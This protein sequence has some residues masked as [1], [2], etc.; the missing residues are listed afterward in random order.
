[1]LSFFMSL[2]YNLRVGLLQEKSFLLGRG[3]TGES[4]ERVQSGQGAL[5]YSERMA[6]SSALRS[7]AL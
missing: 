7:H 4:P 6:V 3:R 5:S 2:N 1:M